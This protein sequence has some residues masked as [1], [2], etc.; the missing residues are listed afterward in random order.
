MHVFVKF[1]SSTLPIIVS[2]SS[3]V[4][5]IRSEISRTNNLSNGEVRIV[6]AGKELY[7]HQ[8]LKD[9]D[10]QSQTVVHAFRG[11]HLEPRPALHSQRSTE[12]RSDHNGSEESSKTSVP[13]YF[14]LCRKVCGQ[15][16]PGKLRI[17]CAGCGDDKIV[18][19]SEPHQWSD[20][21]ESG[22]IRGVCHSRG[23]KG[24][25]PQFYF[26]CRGHESGH[27]HVIPLPLVRNNFLKVSCMTCLDDESNPV[28]V[29]PCPSNHAMCV[30]CFES[31][32]LHQLSNRQ[33]VEHDAVGYTL[34]CPGTDRE[35]RSSF[36]SDVHHFSIM[37]PENYERYKQFGAEECLL[38][39]GGVLCPAPN[40]GTGIFLESEE[41]LGGEQENH[42]ECSECGHHFCL[43]CK[44]EYHGEEVCT[45][46]LLEPGT[47]GR[48]LSQYAVNMSLSR[49][50]SES[51]ATIRET[52]KPCPQ[53]S[54]P[55]EKSGG[56]M[57]MEC[58]LARC[59]YSWCWMC[60]SEWTQDCQDN[61]WFG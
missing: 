34:S 35:C 61:H 44:G 33:F 6:F 40:C 20:I 10:I 51:A 5:D 19:T 2:S 18:L 55:V 21:L 13:T 16:K 42:A 28:L 7:D 8:K 37:G 54:T 60:S 23:C 39:M 11:K 57:H 58:P 46:T 29:Y 47:S 52:T 22:R 25:I 43:L 36:I 30:P 49:Y 14:V 45:P 12:S 32:C 38:K 27:D 41:E 26:K 15:V 17:R 31:Y 24:A 53:C 59:H 9:M 1:D 48:V 50:D 3:T 56:C 4:E